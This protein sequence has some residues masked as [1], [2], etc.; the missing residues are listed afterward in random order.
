MRPWMSCLLF[1]CAC[2]QVGAAFTCRTDQY[3]D[4]VMKKCHPCYSLC[5]AETLHTEC[6]VQCP[7]MYNRSVKGEKGTTPTPGPTPGASETRQDTS[8]VPVYLWVLMVAGVVVVGVV[9]TGG[10]VWY[11]NFR[12]QTIGGNPCSRTPTSL[13]TRSR[14][15]SSAVGEEEQGGGGAFGGSLPLLSQREETELKTLLPTYTGRPT[16]SL[17][18]LEQGQ[19]DGG[20]LQLTESGNP[21]CQPE[22]HP[23]SPTGCPVTEFQWCRKEGASLMRQMRESTV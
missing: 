23:N 19:P 17:P 16:A 4:E 8:H 6:R 21:I 10:L 3:Y 7:E 20:E 1:L 13:G 9:V 5:R 12:P 2:M 14:S 18:D 22:S 15:G 11:N